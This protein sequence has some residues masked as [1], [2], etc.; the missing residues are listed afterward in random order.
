MRLVLVANTS[1]SSVTH[2]T[3]VVIQRALSAEH[4]VSF[5][6][7]NRRGHAARLAQGAASD[8]ADVV[9]VLGGDGTLNEAANGL[10][11]SRTALAVIPGGST[12]VF[13]RTIGAENDPLEATTQL[14]AALAAGSVR[15]VG[16]GLA[17]GR[18]FLFHAGIGFDAAVVARV[19]KIA[20]LKRY[21]GPAVFLAAAISTLT[22]GYAARGPRFELTTGDFQRADI[23]FAVCLNTSPYTF[24]GPRPVRLAPGMDLQTPMSM[25]VFDDLSLR[26][27]GRIAKSALGREGSARGAAPQAQVVQGVH[28]ACI[29]TRTPVPYQLD[30]DHL[31]ETT[32][33][34]LQWEPDVLALVLPLHESAP[35]R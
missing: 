2:R 25:V 31:G 16:L 22:R 17:N 19:E 18:Y 1:A 24:L 12:N 23:P 13:A 4:D 8:G 15:H 9:V 35:G 5:A 20:F 28:E 27:L 21:A 14:L 30:G 33:I 32:N 6:P 7:T 11:G 10:A 34:H 29:E 3:R 26:T